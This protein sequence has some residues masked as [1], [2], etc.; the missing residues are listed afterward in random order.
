M[1]LIKGEMPL[2]R[3]AQQ[4]GVERNRIE[5]I[6]NAYVT[7]AVADMDCSQVT[8]LGIDETSSRR[9]HKYVSVAV[10]LVSK[11]VV[12]VATGKDTE[13]VG[14]IREDFEAK[15]GV[16]EQVNLIS[17]DMSP[18]FIKGAGES[19]PNAEITYDKFHVVKLINEA[20]DKTRRSEQASCK[21]LKK[22]RFLW[23]EDDLTEERTNQL[24]HLSIS[25]PT[26]G[27][28]YR[29]KQLFKT[30]WQEESVGQARCFLEAWII[31]A[32]NVTAP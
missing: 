29:L 13:A 25:Y 6:F 12:S 11:K 9:G 17:I 19:F 26:M 7:E 20:V 23:L 15:K 8:T 4:V 24:K 32:R 1:L 14:R 22:T 18:A 16:A 28:A 3:V 2:S 31:K 5:R 21:E 10:D 27:E 30:F